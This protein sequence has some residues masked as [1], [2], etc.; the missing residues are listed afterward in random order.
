MTHAKPRRKTEEAKMAKDQPT[1][2]ML[3]TN[4]NGGGEIDLH[5]FHPHEEHLDDAIVDGVRQAYE[6]GLPTLTIIHGHGRN[7]SSYHPCF[8]NSNTG[9][10]GRTVRSFLRGNS[11]LRQWMFAKIDCSHD[12]STMVRIRRPSG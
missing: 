10:L 1:N 8:V 3:Y 2:I 11:N 5:G 12:G 4:G 9:W 6:N 7:R